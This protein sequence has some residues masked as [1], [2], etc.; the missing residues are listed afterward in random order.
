M[1]DDWLREHV[2]ALDT[3]DPAAPLDDLEPLR[4]LVGEARVVAVGENSH[5]IA[6]FAALRQRVLRFL[7]E[8]CGFTIF[9][10]EYGFSEG[11]AVA[12]WVRGDVDDL[13]SHVDA[14]LPLGLDGPLHW[15][16]EHGSGVRFVGIDIPEAGGSLLPA[17]RPVAGYL[18]GIDPDAAVFAEQA[19]AIAERVARPSAAAGAPAWAR[20]DPSEQDALTAALARLLNRFRAAKALYVDRTDEYGYAV[21]LRR[22]EGAFVA[23]YQIR[24]MAALFAGGGLV[25]DTTA[26]DVYMAESVR[27][28]LEHARPGE[29]ML[30]AAHNAHIQKAPVSYGGQLSAFPMGFHLAEMFGSDYVAL[31]LTSMAGHT[32]EM[33][34]DESAHFGFVVDEQPLAPPEAG[35]VEAALTSAPLS[36]AA[37]RGAPEGGPDRIRMHA[38]YLQL[39]VAAAFD[40]VVCVPESTVAANARYLKSS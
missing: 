6:E 10:F 1:F 24:A 5:F 8:R 4:E 21:N 39:P 9:G 33:E 13:P 27:W 37:L 19:I 26:R 31:A 11:F 28:H 20:L 32:A 15:L 2:H 38:G 29:R 7:V 35:S 34:L 3:T 12:D 30:L 16:R 23:D 36:L 18:Q 14:E 40:G 25:A 22:V 17:L